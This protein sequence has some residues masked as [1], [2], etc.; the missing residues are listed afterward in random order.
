MCPFLIQ[1]KPLK[2]AQGEVVYSALFLEWFS[3]EARRIYGDIIYTP[4]RDRRALVLKQ[5][6]GVAAVITPV[7]GRADRWGPGVGDGVGLGR[8][9]L[10]PCEEVC[11]PIGCV[12]CPGS[13]FLCCPP[14]L[15]DTQLWEQC[16][17]M[18]ACSHLQR[19]DDPQQDPG[20]FGPG[21]KAASRPCLAHR[22]RFFFFFKD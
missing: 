18:P 3:E 22:K 15:W 9:R 20:L 19:R 17:G 11:C 16:V 6:L 12:T 10:P 7:R 13:P 14:V 1:G 2:E 4:T 8:Y 21:V 5:P